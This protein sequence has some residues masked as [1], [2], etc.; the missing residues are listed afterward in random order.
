MA[1]F[2]NNPS[3]IAARNTELSRPTLQI[4]S[5][6]WRRLFTFLRRP[7]TF[8][9]VTSIS[10]SLI[11]VETKQTISLERPLL[12]NIFNQYQQLSRLKVI[13]CRRVE[14]QSGFQ[15][16]LKVCFDG[17]TALSQECSSSVLNQFDKQL[18]GINTTS[19]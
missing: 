5:T 10:S 14:V 8:K 7:K 18:Q 9:Q 1:L 15:Y 3:S 19:G 2:G 17:L 16:H 12:V 4:I 11:I 13:V 6:G